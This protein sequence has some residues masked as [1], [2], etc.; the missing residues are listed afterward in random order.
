MLPPPRTSAPIAAIT[1]GRTVTNWSIDLVVG[2][3]ESALDAAAYALDGG[4]EAGLHVPGKVEVDQAIGGADLDF[5]I[6][7]VRGQDQGVQRPRAGQL[8]DGFHAHVDAGVFQ[9]FSQPRNGRAAGLADLAN[10]LGPDILSGGGS[11]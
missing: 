9:E 7:I 6:V 5:G 11:D 10:V 4:A 2:V 8:L 3:G 1:S